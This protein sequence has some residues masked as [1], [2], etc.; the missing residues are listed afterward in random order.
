MEGSSFLEIVYTDYKNPGYLLKETRQLTRQPARCAEF[1][2]SFDFKIICWSE[3][4]GGTP[5]AL[6][7]QPEFGR[8]GEY[9]P[10]G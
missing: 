7:P 6:S 2:S 5:E 9:T 3:T 1:I 4:V 10:T 8:Q